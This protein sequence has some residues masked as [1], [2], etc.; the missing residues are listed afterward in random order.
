M[1]NISVLYAKRYKSH[2]DIY[3]LKVYKKEIAQL[4]IKLLFFNQL[5]TN[6]LKSDIIIISS[7]KAHECFFDFATKNKIDIENNNYIPIFKL[8]KSHGPSIIW[9]D[10]SDTTGISFLNF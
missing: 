7:Y 8:I 2:H 3:P 6:A 10:T 4:N 5:N 9:F 1:L